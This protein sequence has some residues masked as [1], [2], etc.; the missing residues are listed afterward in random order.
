MKFHVMD[1]SL[2]IGVHHLEGD[3][4]GGSGFREGGGI[5]AEGSPEI[6]FVGLIDFL[7]GYSLKKETEHL[8]RAAQGHEEDASCVHP[9][10]YAQ[11][12]VRF[13]REAVFGKSPISSGTLG[14]LQISGLAAN[15]LA[16]KDGLLDCSDPYVRV[17]VGLLSSETPSVRNNLNPTW[18]CEL[19]IP[20]NEH[21]IGGIIELSV[22]D[23][24][25]V[26]SLRGADDA[27]GL[28]Q[29]EGSSLLSGTPL[30]LTQVPLWEIEQGKFTAK[31]QLQRVTGP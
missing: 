26:K 13:V 10:D 27:L 1:Y 14:K 23:Y 9:R 21:H 3:K 31:L 29:V 25:S 12:Q 2:L 11:R 15:D 6:Y 18:D 30:E 22:W 28:I 5:W 17:S 8:I 4:A 7:I 20:I 24:D 16:N 19:A